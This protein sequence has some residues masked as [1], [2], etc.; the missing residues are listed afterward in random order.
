MQI[1]VVVAAIREPM[2]QIQIAVGIAGTGPQPRV[3]EYDRASTDEASFRD[4]LKADRSQI[5]P[6]ALL[7]LAAATLATLQRARRLAHVLLRIKI[8]ILFAL[9][10]AEVIRLP[11]VLGSSSCGSRV[12]VHTAHRIF[13]GCCALHD[14][15]SFV[16]EVCSDDLSHVD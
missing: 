10:A 2:S 8:E 14:H 3:E 6:A 5:P 7:D 11:I 12:Y 1:P 4:L 16:G 13:H 9:G 15:L